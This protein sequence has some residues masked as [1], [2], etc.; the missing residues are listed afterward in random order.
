MALLALGRNNPRNTPATDTEK[1][2]NKQVFQEGDL[3]RELRGKLER[4]ADADQID[5]R[6][7]RDLHDDDVSACAGLPDETLIA[8][9]RSLHDTDLRERG[10]VPA[11]ETAVAL[12]RSCGPVWVHPNVASVAPVVDGWARL[13]GCGW[14]HLRNRQLVPHPPV[15]CG[16]CQHFI[17]DTVNPDGG[18][19]RCGAGCNPERPWP[20][21]RHQ[22]TE[23]S[24]HG[25]GYA[26]VVATLEAKNEKP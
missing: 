19:G 17:R 4:V 6:L 9:V 23:F 3:L 26:D 18:M 24:P 1:P 13:L 21:V 25:L 10:K 22:C 15:A 11:D 7:V 20:T 16:E 5:P 14:C 8:Y 2:R 12:C